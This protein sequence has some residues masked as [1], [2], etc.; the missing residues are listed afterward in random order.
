MIKELPLTEFCPGT[1]QL[2][3]PYSAEEFLLMQERQEYILKQSVVAKAFYLGDHLLCYAGIIRRCLFSPPFLW[4][5]LGKN[6]T[7][8]SA[9][10]LRKL[11]RD[12][13]TQYPGA[14]TL[15]EKQYE[16]GKRL[17]QFYGLTPLDKSIEIC[18]RQF[19]YYE[20]Q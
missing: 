7:A 10:P 5:L 1:E 2:L 13:S 8:K 19:T 16:P 17:A 12:F 6:F 14:Q 20:V 3:F 15:I 9:R 4:V 18:A 11:M